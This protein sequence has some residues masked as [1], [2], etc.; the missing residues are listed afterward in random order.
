MKDI[1]NLIAE[2]VG[3][4]SL[5]EK[6]ISAAVSRIFDQANIYNRGTRKQ[7]HIAMGMEFAGRILAWSIHDDFMQKIFQRD[8]CC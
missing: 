8:F 3:D 2:F 1:I 7:K 4:Y 5:L 6:N